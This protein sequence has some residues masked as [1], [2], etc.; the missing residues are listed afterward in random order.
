MHFPFLFCFY[1]PHFLTAEIKSAHTAIILTRFCI[2]LIWTYQGFT[3][4]LFH[5]LKLQ[6]QFICYFSHFEELYSW[7]QRHWVHV[8][9]RSCDKG[10]F[11]LP[12]VKQ[13]QVR[14][15]LILACFGRLEEVY[16]HRDE[17]V[18]MSFWNEKSRTRCTVQT[19]WQH[20]SYFRGAL[21]DTSFLCF[22]MAP[23]HA[24]SHHQD[25]LNGK[26]RL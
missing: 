4:M 21:A 7:P 26:N 5:S 8:V 20:L 15:C 11:Q 16:A 9:V 19:T 6:C 14:H 10:I 17:I 23:A 18:W 24:K 25:S 3:V 12:L 2:F 22:W 1:S 13:W